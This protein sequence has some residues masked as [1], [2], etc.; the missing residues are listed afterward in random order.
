[1]PSSRTLIFPDHETLSCAVALFFAEA[2]KEAITARGRFLVSISGGETPRLLYEKLGMSPYRDYLPWQ[3]IHIFWSDERCVPPD[4]PDS[5]YRQ[6]WRTWLR[7]IRIP[8]ENLHRIHAELD[9]VQAVNDYRKELM[10]F[11][12]ND[13]EFPTLDWVLLGLGADGHTASVFPGSTFDPLQPVAAI[14]HKA[15]GRLSNRISMTPS[16]IN[17]S[18]Q[19]VCMVSGPKKAAALAAS[20]QE[21]ADPLLWPAIRI[22]PEHG[23]LIWMVDEDAIKTPPPV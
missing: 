3:S 8:P 6:A 19:V 23:M 18:R 22:H 21:N 17:R 16:L 13:S 1:M 4:D 10:E 15:L 5:N 14:H 11:R 9:P 7:H 20:R 2:A 12:E